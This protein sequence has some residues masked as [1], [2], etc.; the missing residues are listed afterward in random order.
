MLSISKNKTNTA[1]WKNF[2][3]RS[4]TSDA[5]L[6]AFFSGFARGVGD[7]R[8]S[9]SLDTDRAHPYCFPWT[10]DNLFP[11]NGFTADAETVG[12]EYGRLIRPSVLRWLGQI[13]EDER[14]RA[15]SAEAD[16]D[17]LWP[18]YATVPQIKKLQC[19]G[20]AE[21]VRRQINHA[22]RQD[23]KKC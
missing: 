5:K 15:A 11:G 10:G 3:A 16:N 18:L 23:G 20:G 2:F 21:W 12:F 17:N 4:L 7:A 8:Y 14:R 22:I 19:L 6:D 1:A 9:M 13:D